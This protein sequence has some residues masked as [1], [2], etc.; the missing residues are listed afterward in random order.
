MILSQ[1]MLLPAVLY[2]NRMAFDGPLGHFAALKSCNTQCGCKGWLEE[3]FFC[4]KSC[5]NKMY[6]IFY[7]L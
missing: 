3:L 2:T 7:N 5:F 4:I 1:A 6:L